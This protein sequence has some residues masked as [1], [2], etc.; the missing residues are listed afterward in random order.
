[1]SS[2]R[3]LLADILSLAR[4]ASVM[5]VCITFVAERDTTKGRRCRKCDEVGWLIR[6]VES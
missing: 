5:E 4:G 2:V 1:M 6:F 3:M